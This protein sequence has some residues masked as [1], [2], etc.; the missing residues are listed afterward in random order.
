M[1]KVT[2]CVTMGRN[3]GVMPMSNRRWQ[4]ARYTVQDAVV[5]LG[6]DIIFNGSGNGLWAGKVTEEA[7]ALVAFIP[8]QQLPQLRMSLRQIAQHYEQEALGLVVNDSGD[9]SLVWAQ[10]QTERAE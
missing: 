10:S 2:I 3:I 8:E 1:S 4:D 5:G 6:G 9:A 7:V